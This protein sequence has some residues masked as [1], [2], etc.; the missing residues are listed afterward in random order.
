LGARLRLQGEAATGA[1]GSGLGHLS[2]AVWA[3][4]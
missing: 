1:V 4:C 2:T 3:R